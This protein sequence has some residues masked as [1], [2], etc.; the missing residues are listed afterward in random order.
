MSR[1]K[2]LIAQERTCD[3]I[4]W[5]LHFYQIR[6]DRIRK[7]GHNTPI[8]KKARFSWLF[9]LF[10][11]ISITLFS[12]KINPFCHTKTNYIVQIPSWESSTIQR[13]KVCGTKSIVSFF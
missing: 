10:R 8:N 11:N 9:S 2:P 5:N 13:L 3:S 1:N 6:N 7:K 12:K 4:K